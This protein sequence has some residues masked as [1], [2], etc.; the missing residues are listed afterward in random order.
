MQTISSSRPKIFQWIGTLK[1]YPA[2][3]AGLLTGCVVAPPQR[4]VYVTPTR[5][6]LYV[7]SIPT[8]QYPSFQAS[9]S[10]YEDPPISEPEPIL[11]R[12]APP[13]M[14]VEAPYEMPYRG[15]V[16][17]GGYW[18]W[19]GNWVWSHGRWAGAP[20]PNYYW[21]H[22]YYENRGGNVVF[23][24]GYWCPP[25]AVFVA[26]SRSLNIGFAPVAVGVVAG[27][28]V[29]GP[30]GVFVPAPP[31]S[32]F[33]L[34]V[35]APIGT[36]PAVV[37]G[38]PP[39][40]NVGMRIYNNVNSNNTTVNGN[41][42]SNVTN[43][44]TNVT[45]VTNVTIAAP[46]SATA[47]GQSVNTIL[48]AQAHVAA[49]MRPV[50]NAIAPKPTDARQAAA[51]LNSRELGAVPTSQPAHGELAPSRENSVSSSVLPKNELKLPTSQFVALPAAAPAAVAK[52]PQYV[53]STP[54]PYLRTNQPRPFNLGTTT[55]SSKALLAASLE[56][57]K[58][59][60]QQVM[61]KPAVQANPS[62]AIQEKA[63]RPAEKQ[64]ARLPAKDREDSQAKANVDQR[65]RPQMKDGAARG[66]QQE[67][68][69][70]RR[71]DN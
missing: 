71:R 47:S 32:R 29:I 27:A 30:Q 20:R 50:V 17:I 2:V 1:H 7:P 44:T 22:P 60:I 49:A 28:A 37:T 11:V 23:I 68:E 4:V 19:N 26:P 46:A 15:A 12:W 58:Q 41:F 14:L 25:T 21:V 63:K 52:S 67:L 57:A 55:S 65:A 5:P 18:V 10:V 13:P 66:K 38:A 34:I 53:P 70:E 42:T 43:N 33:G 59:R 9:I 48:P 54:M 39:I 45:N 8:P 62:P 35:P 31:G 56:Q 69:H 3:L 16:W 40:V 36:P 51:Y 6:P 64:V 24:T 61:M